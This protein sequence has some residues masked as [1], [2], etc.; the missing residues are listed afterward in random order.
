VSKH[1]LSLADVG[2]ILGLTAD[3]VG[4][5]RRE[6]QGKGRYANHP[7]PLPDGYVGNSPYWLPE[8]ATEI[9]NWSVTRIGRGI[10]GG[11]RPR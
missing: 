11:P 10:G 5:Y 9:S 2:E 3:T 6:S 7:F 8:R 1:V 4:R